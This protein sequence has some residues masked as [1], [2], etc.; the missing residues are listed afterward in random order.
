[1]IFRIVIFH[2]AM[3]VCASCFVCL[4][5][6]FCQSLDTHS[7]SGILIYLCALTINVHCH[8][9][10]TL[11]FP[12]SFLLLIVVILLSVYCII[13]T[14]LSTL[15]SLLQ[16]DSETQITVTIYYL[17]KTLEFV[18][19]CDISC[20]FFSTILLILLSAV[21]FIYLVSPCTHTPSPSLSNL[22]IPLCLNN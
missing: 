16:I 20:R 7:L 8:L 13:M 4:F 6:S 18:V 3:H 22:H 5:A 9:Y 12:S 10:Y 21:L 11:L 19:Y 15:C 17:Y 1:M 14:E 2:H